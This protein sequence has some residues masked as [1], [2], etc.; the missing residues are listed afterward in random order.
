V[1]F[2]KEIDVIGQEM[3]D[4]LVAEKLKDQKFA[5]AIELLRKRA[6]VAEKVAAHVKAGK[7]QSP[8]EAHKA[9]T[10]E[11]RRQGLKALKP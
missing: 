4:R 7:Y 8:E 1:W 9:F 6:S 11:E 2:G 5:D 3:L 10:E